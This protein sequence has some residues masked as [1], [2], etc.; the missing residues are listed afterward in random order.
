M[1]ASAPAPVRAHTSITLSA[2]MVSIPLAVYT[3]TEDTKVTR[4]E[5][6]NGDANIPLGRAVVRKDNGDVVQATDVTRMAEA[7]NGAWV[8]L[9]DDEVAAATSPKGLAEVVSFVP[10]DEFDAYLTENLYQVRVKREKGKPNPAADKAL[11]LLL[12]GMRERQVGALIKVAMR[13]PARYAI[14]TVEGDLLMVKPSDAIRQPQPLSDVAVT[15]AE[16]A[17][18]VSLI[19]AIGIGSPVITDDTAPVVQA[20][21]DSKAQG[22]PTPAPVPVAPID[23]LMAAFEA[24]IKA[25]Q[26]AKA[27]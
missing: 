25:A 15:A 17:M 21:V 1:Y 18:A 16:V 7:S 26:E 27:A 12:A 20:Y 11:S 10:V 6:F 19:D 22:L 4:K 2:L 9:T 8:V 5:F 24:S 23:D 14:L 3:G 13:G